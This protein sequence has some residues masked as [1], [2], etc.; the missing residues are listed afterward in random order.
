MQVGERT[1]S[2]ADV[3]AI[4]AKLK[5]E[6]TSSFYRELGQALISAAF[7]AAMTGALGYALWIFGHGEKP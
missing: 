5:S 3:A 4:A 1:L 2:D 6:I 7:K